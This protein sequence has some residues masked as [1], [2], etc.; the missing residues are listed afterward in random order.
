MTKIDGGELVVR[1][2][3]AGGVR[4]IFALHG[5]HLEPILQSC[6]DHSLPLIDTRHEAAAGHAAEGYAKAT[7]ELGV[8]LVTAGPGFT[9]VVTALA[10][11]HLDGTPIL[12]ITGASPLRDAETNPLQGGFDQVAV[13]APVTKWAHRV[14][15]VHRIPH[16]VAH[17]IR[18]ATTGRPGPVL[19]EIPVDVIFRQVN[20]LA[21]S[22]PIIAPPLPATPAQDA[23][24]QVL[25]MLEKVER[26]IIMAGTGAQLSQAGSDLM[27][28]AELTGVPVFTNCK[29]HGVIPTD[30]PLCGHDFSNLKVLNE[31]GQGPDAVLLLGAKLGRYT[32]GVTDELIPFAARFAVVDIEPSEIGRLRD[33]EI[34]VHADVAAALGAFVAAAQDRRWPDRTAWQETV[35]YNRDW[36]RRRY[37]DALSGDDCPI[38]PYRAATEVMEALE[39][40]AIVVTD[41]GEAY[42]W[43]ELAARVEGH[44]S[45]MVTGYLGCLGTG[46]PFAMGAKV[47]HPDRQVVCVT[48]DGAVGFNIQEFDTLVRHNLPVVTVVMNNKCWGMSVHGQ[49]AMYG[50]NRLT[51]S[52]LAPSRYDQVAEAFG[53]HGELV[54]KPDEVRPAVARALASGRPACVNVMIDGGVVAP[55]TEAQLG[56]KTKEA[57]IILPYYDNL[58]VE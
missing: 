46:V 53:C 22:I 51:I 48:G 23:V 56:R 14:T 34:P 29:A 44:G 8:A 18:I 30:H 21:V 39:D 38:H 20:E 27:R 11:A 2:L 58:D 50:K 41:G 25:A 33:A 32:G 12:V 28:L 57:E 16:L 5:G 13:A 7:G 36:H 37:A 40:D 55:F 26:P 19:L 52:E 43:T 54:T 45:F 10:D 15:D 35:R 42:N 47:A 6:L 17:A 3:L 4:H 31:Q 49:E 24:D 9:N 1:T